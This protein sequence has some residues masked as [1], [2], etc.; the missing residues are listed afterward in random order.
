M[1][2]MAGGR[3]AWV[4]AGI[5]LVLAGCWK[6]NPAFF[7]TEGPDTG[8]SG[9]VGT[10]NTTPA[11]SEPATTATTTGETTDD[12]TTAVD[13]SQATTTA[14][15][16]T[17]GVSTSG[18]DPTTT[19]T[20]GDG[21]S[22]TGTTG[23]DAA[24]ACGAT[25][26]GPAE[27]LARVWHGPIPQACNDIPGRNFFIVG[28]EDDLLTSLPC[29]ADPA[30]GC[31]G[32]DFTKA[33]DFSIQTPEPAGVLDL[34]P[35][36]YLSAHGTTGAEPNEPCRYRQLALWGDGSNTPAKAAPLAVFGHDT[37]DV[38][39]AV[40]AISEA[41][42]SVALAPKEGECSCVDADDC[43]PD[44]AV[45]YNLRF[46]AGELVEVAPGQHAKLPLAG[47]LYEAYN[48]QAFETGACAQEQRFDWW[49]LR[50]P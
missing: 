42:L 18:P 31:V 32:C 23:E 19:T 37:V 39:P 3:A 49:L 45:E 11:G 7:V 28:V 17:S 21:T 20:T 27:L 26:Y 46:A 24:P 44:K 33:L 38:D 8:T 29:S 36:V 4:A 6:D 43:C 47:A 9:A 35:C 1:Q 41:M 12:A 5:G 50:H 22:S 13:P 16:G 2:G 34:P 30:V 25:G 10:T 14:T 48:G 40:A 15:P